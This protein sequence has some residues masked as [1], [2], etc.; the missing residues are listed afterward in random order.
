MFLLSKS[1]ALP[2]IRLTARKLMSAVYTEVFIF[3]KRPA[4]RYWEMITEA[5][6][7]PPMAIMI[8]TVVRE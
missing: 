4:P 7:P 5:P 2:R 6:I 8:K 3:L 1:P